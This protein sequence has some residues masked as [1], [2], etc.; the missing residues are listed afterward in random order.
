MGG[1]MGGM[2]PMGHPDNYYFNMIPGQQHS[3]L[4][5]MEAD[6]DLTELQYTHTTKC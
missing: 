6:Y 2:P 3:Y 5:S 1:G 4:D